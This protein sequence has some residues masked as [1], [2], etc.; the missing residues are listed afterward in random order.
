MHI[1]LSEHFTY[2]KLLRFHIPIHHY[3]GADLHLW[4]CRW[5]FYLKLYRRRAF[6]CGQHCHAV[7][8]DLRCG[9]IYDWNRRQCPRCLH[10][11]RWR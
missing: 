8:D 4:C 10:S 5:I 9:R 7:P 2:S 11:G 3:D 1:E 6:C